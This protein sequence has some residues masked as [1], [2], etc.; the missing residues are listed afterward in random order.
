[1]FTE[2]TQR[3]CH[4]CGAKPTT[5]SRIARGVTSYVYNGLDRLNNA[6]GYTLGNVVPCCATC[7]YFKGPRSYDE[8]MGLICRIH[9]HQ[10]PVGLSCTRGFIGPKPYAG[11]SVRIGR[12]RDSQLEKVGMDGV[13]EERLARQA[14]VGLIDPLFL[15]PG[16]LDAASDENNGEKRLRLALLSDAVRVIA[17]AVA[18]RNRKRNYSGGDEREAREWLMSDD[19]EW[20]YS[21][22][23]VCDV[24]GLDPTKTR[25]AILK[26]VDGVNVVPFRP[27]R[28]LAGFRTQV[29]AAA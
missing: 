7:N 10:Y 2:L 19:L 12:G 22:Q 11:E 3:D 18:R 15:L 4:Y 28:R 17:D 8:F 26:F 23:H 13:T 5:E 1:M 25:A 6:L 21:Y 14:T 24:L 29:V 27:R 20:P 16:Q 9:S